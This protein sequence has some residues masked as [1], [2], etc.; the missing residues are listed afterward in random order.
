MGRA[1]SELIAADLAGSSRN[2]VIPSSTLQAAG[3]IL[4]PRPASA[5]GVS[6]EQT[7]A[8]AAG[9]TRIIFGAISEV[10]GR[11]RLDSSLYNPATLKTERANSVTGPVS[12]GII[13]LAHAAAR[14]FGG[15]TARGT[16]REE[17]LKHFAGAMES[18]APEETERALAASVAADPGFGPAWVSWVQL[19]ISRG[20]RAEAERVLSQAVSKSGMLA[21]RDRARLALS[22]ATLSGDHA[23]TSRAMERLLEMSPAD[24]TLFRGVASAE[25]NARQFT[26]AAR[27]YRKAIKLEPADPLLWNQLG[28]AQAYAGDLEGSTK[29][30]RRYAEMRPRDVNPIDSLGDVNFL[31]GSFLDAEKFYLE[32]LSKDRNFENGS[33]GVKA[34]WARLMTGD[35]AGAD[36]IFAQYLQARGA[37][38]DPFVAYQQ[39][40]WEFITG[41]RTQAMER[42][43]GFARSA[44][45]RLRDA[46]ANAWAQLAVWRLVLGDLAAARESASR[47]AAAAGP[48]SAGVAAVSRFLTGPPMRA[49][50]VFG[51]SQ[52]RDP[53]LAYSLL[54]ARRFAEAEPVLKRMYDRSSPVN[55][56]GL[57]VLL[58]WARIETGKFTEAAP[59]LRWNP[60][61]RPDA[62]GLFTCL[63]FPRLVLLRAQ[64]LE[65]QGRPDEARKNRDLYQ[66]L[67]GGLPGPPA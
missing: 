1:A 13:P 37:A 10:R 62:S 52:L 39:A 32:A 4:G 44:G 30:L 56:N 12:E 16:R 36:G 24:P 54:F 43:G 64:V 31:L 7:E 41:R 15:E 11:L 25:M 51:N 14:E 49:E 65:K 61:P 58:A 8:L 47:A 5:P 42:L 63:Y 67:Q 20:N 46:V 27:N 33:D 34:A 9:A 48:A 23:A 59:L 57:P 18:D 60:I 2:W 38:G 19:E 6:S 40:E 21:E 45:P 3:R 66:K 50:A 29:S 22:A 55:E 28:Y 26:E 53:A 35:I 17:A